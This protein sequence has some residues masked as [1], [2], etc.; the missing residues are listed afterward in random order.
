[1]I[2]NNL[3]NLRKINYEFPEGIKLLKESNEFTYLGGVLFIIILIITGMSLITLLSYKN[4]NKNKNIMLLIIF[5]IS[6][7]DLS[8]MLVKLNS[9]NDSCITKKTYEI[10]ITDYSKVVPDYIF[11]NY[12]VIGQGG[13]I[14]KVYKK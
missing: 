5:I 1:M 6:V 7:I 13:E 3:K 12:K 14:Y 10:T 2:L 9:E 4:F 8:L 11:K